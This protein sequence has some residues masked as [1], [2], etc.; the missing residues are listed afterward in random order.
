MIKRIVNNKVSRK[1]SIQ[2]LIL[3]CLSVSNLIYS[4]E[5]KSSNLNNEANVITVAPVKLDGNVLFNLRGV[6]SFP[7]EKRSK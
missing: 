1:V 4:Q 2:V 7:A 6:S 5:S 3:L